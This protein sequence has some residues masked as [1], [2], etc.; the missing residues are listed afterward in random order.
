MLPTVWPGDLLTLRTLSFE[1][2]A[3]GDLVLYMRGGRFFVHRVVRKCDRETN[4]RLITRGDCM[5]REDSPVPAAQL[6]GKVTALERTGIPFPSGTELSFFRRT[7]AFGLRR[8]DFL[9]RAAL[10]LHHR[11]ERH[12]SGW[13]RQLWEKIK[14]A[15][16]VARSFYLPGTM[17]LEN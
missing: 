17:E 9:Q 7:L 2:A 1:K 6:L 15:H 12:R 4:A 11:C 13:S 5:R 14:V 16:R 8:C 10:W 3:P